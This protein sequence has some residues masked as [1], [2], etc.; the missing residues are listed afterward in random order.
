MPLDVPLDACHPLRRHQTPGQVWRVVKPLTK[1][2]ASSPHTPD[3]VTVT[4]GGDRQHPL[5]LSQGK[6][7]SGCQPL[8]EILVGLSPTP[9][10]VTP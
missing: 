10:V 6:A 4:S 5:L 2:P 9:W 1:L 7:F 8:I 3:A